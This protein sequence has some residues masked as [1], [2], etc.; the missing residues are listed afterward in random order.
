MINKNYPI[1]LMLLL[2]Q[3]SVSGQIL[4]TYNLYYQDEYQI[5]PASLGNYSSFNAIIDANRSSIDLANSPTICNISVG[6]P[7]SDRVAVGT[8]LFNDNR[9]AFSNNSW[10]ATYTYK[11]MFAEKKHVINFGLSAGIYW[12]SF[13]LSKID[14]DIND[15]LL[16][17]AST[18]QETKFRS[19]F[20]IWYS[21]NNLNV[22]ISAPYISQLYNHYLGFVSYRINIPEVE[23]LIIQP[24]VLYQYLPDRTNQADVN[25]KVGYDFVW[26]SGSYRSNNSF[27]AALGFNIHSFGICYT[28]EINSGYLNIVS[29]NTQEIMLVYNFDIQLPKSKGSYQQ[30]E[31]PWKE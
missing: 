16:L 21:W 31:I 12:Q 26:I 17:Q 1:L 24:S 22:A 7:I 29:K 27:V 15:P 9:G 28:Y 6:G 14:A 3:L 11:L 2:F 25:L 23:N 10:L 30:K 20:G 8:R 19:D 18:R 4:Q 5:N 13:N